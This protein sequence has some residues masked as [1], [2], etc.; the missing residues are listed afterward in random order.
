MKILVSAG[1]GIVRRTYLDLLSQVDQ[2]LNVPGCV[3]SMLS[4]SVLATQLLLDLVEI[5]TRYPLIEEK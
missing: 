5:L 3:Q 4:E 1:H 2:V